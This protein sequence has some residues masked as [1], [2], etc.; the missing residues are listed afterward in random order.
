MT[1]EYQQPPEF[2]RDFFNDKHG[3]FFVDIGAN[4]GESWSNTL[5]LE[6]NLG[7]SG[8]CIEPHPTMFNKLVATRDVECINVAVA[9]KDGNA[10]FLCIEGS[11]EANMLSGLVDKYDPQHRERVDKEYLRYG[12]TS[13]NI[14]VPV[15]TLQSILNTRNISK[16]D[17][18]SIDTEGAELSI[19]QGLDLLNVDV[20]LISVETNYGRDVFDEFLGKYGFKFITKVA[21]DSFYA[22]NV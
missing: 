16:I 19:L 12:G 4:D 20:T 17:Y 6:K 8:L 15:T 2:T 10:D 5:F 21:C 14:Q 22:K 13:T 9:D 18:L 7:W 3:L 1:K 11:W